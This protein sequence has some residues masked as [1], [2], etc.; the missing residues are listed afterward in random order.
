[1]LMTNGIGATFGTLVAGV[2]VNHYCHWETIKGGSY[3]VGEWSHPWLIFA[4][5][6]FV[7][8][9][10]FAILFKYKHKPNEA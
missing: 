5:Y 10:L 6:A 8:F 4:A 7:V 1:M 2:I 9:V 3:M